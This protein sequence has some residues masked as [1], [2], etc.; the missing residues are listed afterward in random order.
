MDTKDDNINDEYVKLMGTEYTHPDPTDKHFQNKMYTKRE[1]YYHKMPGRDKLESYKDIKEYRDNVC[2]RHFELSEHQ[3]L[4]SNYINPDTPYR[5]ILVFHGTGTGKCLTGDQQVFLDGCLVPIEKIWKMYA[6]DLRLPDDEDP[7][8]EWALPAE[9][10][11]VNSMSNMSNVSNE[12]KK[13]DMKLVRQ[14]VNHLYRQKIN[15]KINVIKLDNGSTLKITKRHKLYTENGWTNDFSKSKYVLVPRKLISKNESSEVNNFQNDDFK[16]VKIISITGTDYD[17]FVYDLEIEEYHNFVAEHALVSNTCAAIAI[18]EKF[19]SMVQKY[20][21][22]IYV[23][24]SGPLIKDNWKN[25]LLK[26]TGETYLKQE[27]ATMLVGEIQKEKA[28]KVAINTALQHYRLMSYR[29]FYKKVLGEKIVEKVKVSE[30]KVKTTYRKTKEGEFERDIAID[31]LYNLNNSIIIVDEAHNLT[32]KIAG[33]NQYGEAL[34]K[35]INNSYNLRIILL[36][37]T[38]MKN[39]A[40]DIVELI[41]F[42]RPKESRMLRDK[43]F[44]SEKNHRMDFKSGGLEYLKE[45]TRGYISYLRGA[46]PLTFAS[47]VEEGVV[48]EGLMFTKVIRCKMLPFQRKAYDEVVTVVDDT[49][50]RRSGAVANF[51]FPGLSK[52]H[53]EVKAYVGREGLNVVKNQI[54]THFD[55]LNKKIGSDIL[56]DDEGEGDFIYL[57]EYGKT[58]NGRIL[59]EKNLKYFSTKFHA[60]LINLNKLV[61]GDKGARTAFIYAN[62]V[63]VGIELFQEILLENGYLEYDENPAN[64]KIKSDTRCYFCGKTNKDHQ[65]MNLVMSAKLARGK[66]ETKIIPEHTFAP[67]TFISITGK[68]TEEAADIIPEDKRKILDNVFSTIDNKNGK[69]LKMILG[70]K[71]MQEGISLKHVSEVHILDVYFNLGKVDQIIGRA[72]RRC[73]HYAMMNEE[74]PYPKVMVYKYV[75]SVDKGLTTEEDMYKKAELKYIMVKKVERALKQVAIDCPHNRSGNVFPEEVD[76][77]RDCY[78]PTDPGKRD[79][80][81]RMCA[82]RCDYT[83]CDFK[84]EDKKLNKLYFDEKKKS[85]VDIS[86][87]KLDYTTFTQSLARNEID[88]AKNIIK[89]MYRIKYV[90]TLPEV[91]KYVKSSYREEKRDLFDEFFVFKALDELIP[92]T[93]NDFNNFKDTIFDKFNK[94]GYVIHVNKYYIFQ[95]FNQPEDVPMYYRSTFDKHITN[96]LTLHNY[97][98][99]TDKF[100]QLKDISLKKKEKT[101]KQAVQPI[102]DFESIMEYYDNRNEYDVVGIIDKESS[103][104]RTRNEEEL[105]DVFK[106]REKRAKIL[107][108]KRA[109]GLPSLRGAVCATSK[110]KEYLEKIAKKVGAKIG[111]SS[112]RTDIC[113]MIKD[114][115]LFLEKYST[116]GKKNKMTYIMVPKNHPVYKFPLNLEDRVKYIKDQISDKIKFPIKIDVKTVKKKVSDED[117]NEYIMEIKHEAKLNDFKEFFVSLGAALVSGKYV[118]K[119]N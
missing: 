3:A 103:R 73:S 7:N 66:E 106:I 38:P 112:I 13:E 54:K 77:Y 90:Y 55:I 117:V 72:I 88:I 108:K 79:P 51:A 39:L 107:E 94:P 119:I 41:N 102:Y 87:N 16:F 57:S 19:K 62:L 86:R 23:L 81:K 18:A 46:D 68:S 115:L 15:E 24:V 101:I 78:G 37:A 20:G 40:H 9:D 48:P 52:D 89:D 109:T 1:F 60:V 36:T 21:T 8:G 58:I 59:K 63:K 47:R 22:K 70:S 76:R 118:I 96:Q 61:W 26:C 95:P 6:S 25:E 105:Q 64:Y 84:C 98:K 4:L 28:K 93:E 27:D 49:L 11:Y 113:E 33:L 100:K 83:T 91:V 42:I 111:K 97:M 5:G 114:R 75:V 82:S 53:K 104:R 30:T 34:K 29:S 74:T 45:M 14:K 31:R 56:K 110:D 2:S 80:N 35:I 71:V 32:G 116:S 10:I 92:I 69:Y 99:N 50:D 67:A 43:I 44:T 17:G 85:Y 65:Q 12:V